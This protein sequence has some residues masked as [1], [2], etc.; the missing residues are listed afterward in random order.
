V[1][2]IGMGV[3]VMT[4]IVAVVMIMGVIV[5][6]TVPVIMRMTIVAACADTF[7]M[8]MMAF[9]R[10]SDFGFETKDLF[11]IL[12]HLAIH[13]I[14][15]FTDLDH[16]VCEGFKHLWMIVEIWRFHELEFGM[17]CRD[18]IGVIIDAFDQDAGEQKIREHHNTFVGWTNGKVTPE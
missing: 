4:M 6:M 7:D 17:G 2:V 11:A 8:V 9:L 10:Q 14:G 16:S 1:R 3:G 15:T 12:A 5:R 13:Q 18:Q